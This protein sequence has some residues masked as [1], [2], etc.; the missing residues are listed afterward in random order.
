ML[1][2]L[3]CH[4]PTRQIAM[5]RNIVYLCIGVR[6]RYPTDIM[7]LIYV[8]KY[9]YKYYSLSNERGQKEMLLFLLRTLHFIFELQFWTHSS[10]IL[11]IVKTYFLFRYFALEFKHLL[12]IV[13]RMIKFNYRKRKFIELVV[14]TINHSFSFCCEKI[15]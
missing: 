12:K 5:Y 4:L 8:Y 14:L 7:T 13:K 6:R 15:I 2:T 11:S 9:K 3:K 10:V 1:A